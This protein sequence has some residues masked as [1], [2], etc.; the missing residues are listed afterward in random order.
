[1][2]INEIPS[3]MSIKSPPYTGVYQARP[4]SR[5]DRS[6]L[7]WFNIEDEGNDNDVFP[8][9]SVNGMSQADE[10]TEFHISFPILYEG[11][12]SGGMQKKNY[13]IW[14]K[15]TTK[16]VMRD[17]DNAMNFPSSVRESRL[18][19]GEVYGKTCDEFARQ[20]VALALARKGLPAPTPIDKGIVQSPFYQLVPNLSPYR[21]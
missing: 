20:F 1:M 3:R 17:K 10:F 21:Y 9:V 12:F 6:L 14:Y 15:I 5:K 16:G 19:D 4:G 11:G 2:Q 13:S 18:S 8:H 7:C